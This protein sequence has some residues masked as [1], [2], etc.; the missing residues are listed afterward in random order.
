M[1]HGCHANDLFAG[2]QHLYRGAYRSP[3]FYQPGNLALLRQFC[4]QFAILPLDERSAERAGQIRADLAS[5][6][7]PIGPYDLLI[8][9]IA[10][11]H[12]ATLVTHNIREFGR[13]VGLQYVD[14]QAGP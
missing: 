7:T 11:V 3:A 14:W 1:K 8:A 4:G 10:V 12:N 2:Y 5:K 13:V 6:G 9:A